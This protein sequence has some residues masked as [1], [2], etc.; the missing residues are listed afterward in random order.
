MAH[1]EYKEMIAAHALSALD[2]NEARALNVHLETCAEC[3]AE[4]DDWLE[5]ASWLALDA[6]PQQPSPSVRSEILLK[7]RSDKPVSKPADTKVVAMPKRATTA[8]SSSQ[9]WGAIAAAITITGLLVSL[10]VLWRENVQT[11][12]QLAQI[13]KQVE[14]TRRE[15]ERERAISEILSSPGARLT[16]L[17]GTP[18]APAARAMVAS[19]QTGR[20]MLLAK[21]LPPPPPGKAYQL[22]FIAGGPPIPGRVFKTDRTGEGTLTDHIP[23][24]ASVFAVTLEPETGVDKPTGDIVLKA[25]S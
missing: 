22:W 9:R 1:D 14:E 6:K 25:G 11:K 7:I 24:Q 18:T 20:A 8:W 13:S 23:S 16:E 17:K 5:T 19:E 12:N 21:N 3:R 15:L 2:D 10:F 4:L